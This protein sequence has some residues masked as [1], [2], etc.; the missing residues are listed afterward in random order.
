MTLRGDEDGSGGGNAFL[1]V[2]LGGTPSFVNNF[3]A[4][5]KLGGRTREHSQLV[6]R[7]FKTSEYEKF[8][9][10]E[11][12]QGPCNTRSRFE[13]EV[14]LRGRHRAMSHEQDSH[15]HG[16][17]TTTRDL[18]IRPKRGMRSLSL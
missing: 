10:T 14:L 7:V 11:T 5:A 4:G 12:L 17:A 8:V 1:R 2:L 6:S 15:A 9:R 3:P 16:A 13:P 18:R